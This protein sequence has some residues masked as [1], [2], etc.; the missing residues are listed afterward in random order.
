[1]NEIT[2]GFKDTLAFQEFPKLWNHYDMCTVEFSCS[3]CKMRG[4]ISSHV[5]DNISVNTLEP[6]QMAMN[7]A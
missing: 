5:K 7:D 4:F 3:M 6:S 1:M 2:L